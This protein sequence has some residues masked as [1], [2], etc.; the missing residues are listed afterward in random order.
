MPGN[1]LDDIVNLTL[2]DFKVL[3][4]YSDTITI[5]SNLNVTGQTI[6]QGGT[7]DGDSTLTLPDSTS[8]MYF[9]GGTRYCQ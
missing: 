3:S 8:V 5:P 7:I 4:S 9:E 2:T 1:S 6:I